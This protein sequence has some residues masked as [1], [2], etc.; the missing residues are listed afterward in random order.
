MYHLSSLYSYVWLKEIEKLPDNKKIV[1][2]IGTSYLN[3][4]TYF[5]HPLLKEIAKRLKLN[6]RDLVYLTDR[7]TKNAL[8]KKDNYL[9]EIK[10]RKKGFGVV[11]D[12]KFKVHL[13]G[14]QK[15]KEFKKHF[16]QIN[17]N[18]NKDQN[19]LGVTAQPGKIKGK[20]CIIND[21]QDFEKFKRDQIQVTQMTT[22]NFI[23]I[24]GK[25]KA[26]VTDIG[27]ATCHAAIVSRELKIPCIVGTKIATKVL[28]DGDFV[29]MNANKGIIKKL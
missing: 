6:Y 7:E 4:A 9:E 19:I 13:V 22:P 16:G 15:L 18:I 1:E 25:A 5:I 17:I 29:E 2:L 3:Q 12:K 27:G 14:G 21:T 10:E 23:S 11:F 20:I 28:R 8:L 24:I 26:I